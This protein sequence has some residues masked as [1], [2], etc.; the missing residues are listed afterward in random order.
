MIGTGVFG[1]WGAELIKVNSASMRRLVEEYVVSTDRTSGI[2][3]GIA[4]CT[5]K[6]TFEPCWE[7]ASC[8]ING[9]RT[10]PG[11]IATGVAATPATATSWRMLVCVAHRDFPLGALAVLYVFRGYGHLPAP[12]VHIND[13]YMDSL[14]PL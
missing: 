10:Y 14:N 2:R 3:V 1:P 9:S 11:I 13:Y 5:G 12:N 4:L 7:V 8:R 6:Y